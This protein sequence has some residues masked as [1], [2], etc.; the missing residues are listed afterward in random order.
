MKL[1]RTLI[2]VAV[3]TA[4]SMAQ[5]PLRCD[6]GE[7]AT[8]ATAPLSSDVGLRAIDGKPARLSDL[9]GTPLILNFWATW[10]PPCRR[11]LP[12]LA[13]IQRK[14]A[15]KGLRVVGI[16][17]DEF[18]SSLVREVTSAAGA[19]YLL[20]FGTIDSS[21][22]LIGAQGIP[23]TLFIDRNGKVLHRSVGILNQ[24]ELE[25]RAQDLLK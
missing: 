12:W 18:D 9:R 8:Q 25:R 17:M 20:L 7:S 16:S 1:L 24:Q 3:L 21:L 15:S 19:D 5:A 4:P 2:A 10:C 23:V 6:D 13:A 22:P 14:Y 11:E